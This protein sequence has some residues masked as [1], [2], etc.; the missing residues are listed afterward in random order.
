DPTLELHLPDGSIITNDNWQQAANASSIPA[1]LQ[2]PNANEAA[3]LVSLAPANYTAIVRGANNSTGNALFEAY[4]IGSDNTSG[5][6]NLSTRGFV[7]TGDSIMI[8][9]LIMQGSGGKNVLLRALGPTLGQPPFSV[10]GAL[11]DPF[12]DLRDGNGN[13][14][15]TN[16]NWQQT[17]AAQI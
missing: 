2:P 8:A 5:F 13:P 14:V 17:Q 15:M 1:G 3:I 7:G 6:A 10:P 12:L 4:D 11:A 16:D 9:G